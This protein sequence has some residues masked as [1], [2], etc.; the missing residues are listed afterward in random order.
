MP[1]AAAA[2]FRR[3]AIVG[4]GL[5]GGSIAARL[6]RA[7]P[8]IRILGVDRS[9]VLAR[10]AGAGLIDAAFETIAGVDADL[11]MLATP[12]EATIDLLGS[13]ARPSGRPVISDTCSTK[14]HV[15]AAA[16]AAGV[17]RFVGG[18]PMAGSEHAGLEH[19]D[20]DLF[21]ARPW[22]LVADDEASEAAAA[23]AAFVTLLGARPT[24]VDADW[25]DRTM[26]YVSH[27]PQLLAV[28]LMN[29]AGESCGEQG[30]AAAG[31]AFREMTRLAAS[32]VDLWEGI[33]RTN[34][35]NISAALEAL[36]AE[37]PRGEALTDAGRLRAA[38]LQAREWQTRLTASAAVKA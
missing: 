25:H 21:E 10:A 5:I 19:A 15:M 22:L 4:V 38:F 37:L 30:L 17:P 6:R 33:V 7:A 29:A 26:A 8:D 27:A 34:A 35:D 16:A 20:A 2:P 12:V 31:R 3:V 36:A 11:C 28:T 23:V 9:A 14:R 32:P 18:H 13:G 1:A 24:F